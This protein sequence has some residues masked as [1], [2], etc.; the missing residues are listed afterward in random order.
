MRLLL[1]FGIL[2]FNFQALTQTHLLDSLRNRL[3]TS[4][5]VED[6]VWF[7]GRLTW[8][9]A[10][11]DNAEAFEHARAG[12]RISPDSLNHF[13]FINYIGLIH[14]VEGNYDSS[15]HYLHQS[16]RGL[17]KFGTE[18]Q[19][20]NPLF[21]IGV[22]YSMLGDYEKTLEYYYK[23]M[24]INEKND[25]KGGV[26]NILNSLAIINKKMG[27]YEK[28]REKYRKAIEI[29]TELGLNLEL[30][31]NY[32][33]LANT[34]SEDNKHA[35]SLPFYWKSVRYN[36]LEQFDLGIAS[37]YSNLGQTHLAL[38][39]LD[40]AIFYS[41]EALDLRLAS[42]E[43]MGI[44]EARLAYGEVLFALNRL[45]ECEEQVEKGVKLS[46]EISHKLLERD[47]L[48]LYH[49]VLSR[50]GKVNQAYDELQRF[51]QLRDSL[52]RVEKVKA[53]NELE[54]KYE[55]AKKDNLIAVQKLDMLNSQAEI[56][57]QRNR[58]RW[59]VA[60]SVLSAIVATL[61][62]FVIGQRKKLFK[63]EVLNLKKEKET[64]AVKALLS[65]EEKERDRIAKDLH[66]GLSGILSA[67]KMQF[68]SLKSDVPTEQQSKFD[69]AVSQLDEATSEVRRIAHN[70]MPVTLK[71]FGLI[72]A[73]EAN[74]ETVNS[75]GE[76]VVE[77]QH[78]GVNERLSS[79]FELTVYR[80]IQELMNNI[81]K[82]SKATE[83]LVQINQHDDRLTLSVEDNG[84]GFDPTSQEN[85]EGMGM[86][87]L[88]S[89]VDMF[90]GEISIDS[91]EK[92][93]TIVYIELEIKA[94]Q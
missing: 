55:S 13:T 82:H 68:S 8:N 38:N 69:N 27:E 63:Q 53:T 80:I 9:L 20:T 18:M 22:C 11:R 87:N 72:R 2:L 65:G 24:E 19:T 49:K 74:F 36:K 46:R 41:E 84:Q 86:Q 10:G 75:T 14:R 48:R 88:R 28:A 61:L 76:M 34:Y 25:V 39:N 32:G 54:Y 78:F 59:A 31:R 33:N 1:L 81:I 23:V 56:S 58:K 7:H 77:F 60:L 57:K 15:L 35:E 5:N 85:S 67:T 66:D 93:G 94:F 50:N 83:C 70:L 62:F 16:L 17:G 4:Q 30:A 44:I 52:F 3:A 89:R 29:N 40:S 92:S 42:T 47:C 91:D 45:E 6:S 37:Q 79:E 90:E 51:D 26:A 71:K 43:K 12:L 21:N 64:T 73:L